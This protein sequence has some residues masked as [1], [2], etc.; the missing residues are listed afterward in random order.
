MQSNNTFSKLLKTSLYTLILSSTT[1]VAEEGGSG[2]YLPGS[3]AS[4]MDGVA[5]EPTFLLRV[6]YIYYDGKA[7][8]TIPLAGE[9]VAD[10]EATSN[11]LGITAFWAPE[12]GII[13]DKWNFAMSATIPVVDMKVSGHLTSFNVSDEVTKIGD[14]VLM[15]IMF[16]YKVNDDFN[17]NTRVAFYAP[18]GD[19]ETGRL[20][21]TGKNFWTIEPTIGF[22]YF[23]QKNRREASL[24]FGADFNEENDATNYKSGTQ[25]HLDGTLAQHFPFQ[26]GLAGVGV[27]AYWYNQVTDDSGAGANLGAFRAKAAGVGPVLSYVAHSGKI[28]AE[29]KYINDFNN[30][31]RL[32]GDTLFF[33]I[34]AKF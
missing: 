5:S 24:F 26:N 4:F 23:G 32:E 11:V 15:P 28:L 6:N 12:W 25:I 10:M 20:A 13:D 29:L 21:N 17:I 27:T 16:N 14:I 31:K 30:E 7:D 3:M 2:H 9:H 1:L 19:Y 18:T 8:V 33:K 22:M 34:I